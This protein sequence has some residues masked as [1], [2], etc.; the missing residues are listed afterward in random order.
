MLIDLSQAEAAAY[1]VGEVYLE[2]ACTGRRAQQRGNSVESACPHGVFPSA[3]D[4]RWVA[5]A[6]SGDE[7]WE[8]CARVLGLP[9]EPAWSTLAGRLAARA[10]VEEAVS[11]WTRARAISSLA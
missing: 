2:E 11:A 1:Y 8:R 3:G 4:D 10:A 7:A 9:T 6:V 5:I